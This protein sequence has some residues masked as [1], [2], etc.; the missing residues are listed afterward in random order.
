[1]RA[2]VLTICLACIPALLA[3]DSPFKNWKL[4]WSDEFN[5]PAN[6]PPNPT[7]W[8]YDLGAGGWGNAELETYTNKLENAFE[9]GTGHLIIRAIKQP[10]GA[11]ASA[12]LK[13]QGHFAATYGKIAVR[14]KIP[15]GQG[16]WP[17]FWMLGS[18]DESNKWP[19]CGEIDVM[20]NI[21]KEPAIVH[22][23]VHGPGYSGAQSIGSPFKLPGNPPLSD[24]FH[25]YAVVWDPNSIE[26]F[27]D[28]HSYFTVTPASLPP[29]ALGV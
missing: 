13:T 15:F 24:E 9:D 16:V 28:N 21:G 26:F 12:R 3:A 20:E 23:T 11:I 10:N 22:G 29:C 6:T 18:D 27:I 5:G 2:S 14:M 1:M 8:S 19:A 7:K 4:V 25:E 17:A